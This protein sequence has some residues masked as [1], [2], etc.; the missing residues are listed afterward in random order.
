MDVIQ[1]L[2]EPVLPTNHTFWLKETWIISSIWT[3]QRS[4]LNF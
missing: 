1:H 3:Y 4:S 2:H